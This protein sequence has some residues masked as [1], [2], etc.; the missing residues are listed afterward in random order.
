ME[1]NAIFDHATTAFLRKAAEDPRYTGFKVP[2]NGLFPDLKEGDV[3]LVDT[4]QGLTST[5]IF[6]MDTPNG[7]K[8]FRLQRKCFGGVK[9]IRDYPEKDVMDLDCE[10]D[11]VG[12]V[13]MIFREVY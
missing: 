13:V 1:S 4:A 12:K 9:V 3:V 5:G 2:D 10:P 8:L 11:V 6:A 7:R